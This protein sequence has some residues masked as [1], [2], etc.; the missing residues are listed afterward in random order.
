MLNALWS[1]LKGAWVQVVIIL[2]VINLL[3]F[4]GYHTG[5]KFA[6]ADCVQGKLAAATAATTAAQVK[7]DTYQ[8]TITA[9]DQTIAVFERAKAQLAADAHQHPARSVYFNAHPPTAC[10]LHPLDATADTGIVGPRAADVSQQPGT[11]I[12]HGPFLYSEA[13]RADGDAVRLNALTRLLE[14]CAAAHT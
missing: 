5:H 1:M 7:L 3:F 6:E 9:R 11:G 8:K 12:D 10:T 4:S 14:Q 13:D 2:A